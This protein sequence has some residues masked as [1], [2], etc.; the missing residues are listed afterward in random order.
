LTGSVTTPIYQTSNFA[1]ANTR[2]LVDVISEK[3]EGYFYTRYGNPT[4]RAAEHKMAELECV[5]DAAAFSSG[6]AAISTTTMVLVS[7]GDHIVSVR[8]IY[9]TTFSFFSKVLPRF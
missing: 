7:S 3:K 1:F 6:M 2:D 5:E 4:T 9:G 8:D